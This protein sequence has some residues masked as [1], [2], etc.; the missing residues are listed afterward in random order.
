M[1]NW[2]ENYR[3]GALIRLDA[4]GLVP[5]GLQFNDFSRL[6]RGNLVYNTLDSMNARLKNIQES[7]STR[8]G[9]QY[10]KA[11]WIPAIALSLSLMMIFVN[12]MSMIATIVTY[13]F[14]G[15]HH[16]ASKLAV[17]FIKL[18]VISVFV[19]LA[20]TAPYAANSEVTESKPYKALI[21][22]TSQI[23]PHAAWLID[24]TVRTQP[25]L[26]RYA[27]PIQRMTGWSE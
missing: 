7:S 21:E 2:V 3:Y 15:N 25:I 14:S 22:R 10:V 1:D 9:S 19:L 17:H 4:E 13:M 12:A 24:W 18:S 16:I 6:T 5:W 20:V 27:R 11:L 26:E 23:Q 8:T